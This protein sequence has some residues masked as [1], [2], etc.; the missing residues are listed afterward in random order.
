MNTKLIS[1]IDSRGLKHHWVAR[2]IGVTPSR[3]SLIVRGRSEPSLDEKR[4]L[5]KL[6]DKNMN[7]IFPESSDESETA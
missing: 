7:E 2:K 5:A 6:L 3:L 4:Q 1:E